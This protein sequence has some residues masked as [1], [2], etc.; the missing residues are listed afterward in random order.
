MNAHQRRI[1]KRA[2]DRICPPGT[3]MV[4][5]WDKSKVLVVRKRSQWEH[6]EYQRLPVE[7]EVNP[8][9]WTSMPYTQL[10]KLP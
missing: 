8:F 4:A 10:R 1:F 5:T 9:G 6:A 3:R 2:L 7:A